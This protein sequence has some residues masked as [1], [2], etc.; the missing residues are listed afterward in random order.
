MDK[1]WSGRSDDQLGQE[2]QED[3]QLSVTYGMP[4][5]RGGSVG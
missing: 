3:N 1:S 2:C 4:R 5:G